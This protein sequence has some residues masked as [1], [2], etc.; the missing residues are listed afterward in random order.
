MNNSLVSIITPTYNHEKYI[1]DCISSV[2]KQTYQ[3]WEM[4]I[5]DDG[6]TDNTYKIVKEFAEKEERIKA[7]TQKNVG[8]FRL[9]ETYNFALSVAKGKYIAILEGDDVWFSEKLNLQVQAMENNPNAVLCWGQAYR[10]NA[11]LSDFYDLAPKGFESN[12]NLFLN[13]PVGYLAHETLLSQ[14]FMPALTI[15][16]RKTYLD[17]IGGFIQSHR[18][19][20]VDVPTTMNL[21]MLGNFVFCNEPLGAWRNYPNQ[22]TKTYPA[23]MDKGFYE[24]SLDFFKK[25]KQY[26]KTEEIDEKKVKTRFNKRFIISYSRS[27]RYKLIRKDFK[28]AR[29]DYIQ[30]I[31]HF[32]F[33]EP[34]WKLRSFVGL[35]FSFFHTDVEKLARKLGKITYK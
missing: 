3:N 25:Y 23:E 12:K 13:N 20:L 10:T 21:A 35:L 2:Q 33:Y 28:G 32:G 19:P 9:G 30:S 11:D 1:A 6:S 29:K 15:F 24:F 14:C 27:G 18:L 8:I 31:F 7:F 34:V 16:I 5:V 17:S 26:F 4:I 22:V